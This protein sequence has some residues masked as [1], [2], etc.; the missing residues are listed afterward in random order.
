MPTSD[1]LPPEVEVLDQLCGGPLSLTV[2]LSI[3]NDVI[4]AQRALRILA[5]EGSVEFIGKAD[6]NAPRLPEW[7][8]RQLVDSLAQRPDAFI[9]IYLRLTDRGYEKFA[10]DSQGFFD[11]L[12]SK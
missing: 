10:S 12:F 9:H 6:E 7:Q 1:R 8:V 5:T 4:R 2:I 11:K 3:F